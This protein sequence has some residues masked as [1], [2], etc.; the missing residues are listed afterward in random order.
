MQVLNLG[1]GRVCRSFLVERDPGMAIRIPCPHCEKKVMLSC[2]QAFRGS[3]VAC[4]HCGGKIELVGGLLTEVFWA[5][6]QR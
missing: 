1:A 6:N 5:V 2:A 3:V 4:S